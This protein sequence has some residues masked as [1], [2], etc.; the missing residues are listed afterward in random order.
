MALF[1][2]SAFDQREID[3]YN[4]TLIQ[5]YERVRDFVILHYWA[6]E[7]DDSEFWNHCRMMELPDSLAERIELWTGK[8]RVFR[9]QADLFTEDS[10]IAVLLGQRKL[11]G[12]HDPLVS[13]L[14]VEES[15]RFLASIRDVIQQTALALPTHQQF[16]DRHCRAAA[17]APAHAA[18]A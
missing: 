18:T 5:E 13:M 2:D 4:A 12:S 9:S 11:P 7:R 10:W 14:P 17:A 1:P 8:G 6:T 16:I 3:E 15:A